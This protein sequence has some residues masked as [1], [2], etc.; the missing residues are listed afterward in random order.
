MKR[1]MVI[2]AAAAA[3]GT[4]GCGGS[5]EVDPDTQFELDVHVVNEDGASGSVAV[6]AMSN[7]IDTTCND[8]CTYAVDADHDA[9]LRPIDGGDTVF[10]G[11]SGDC[12]GTGNVTKTA[13]AG[14]T[15]DCTATFTTAG[16]AGPPREGILVANRR[17]CTPTAAP[18][19]DCAVGVGASLNVNAPSAT[20][21]PALLTA[22]SS[23]YYYTDVSDFSS[24]DHG[25]VTLVTSRMNA[26]ATWSN[27][28]YNFAG[29]VA[30]P[31]NDIDALAITTQGG[32]VTIDSAPA[33]T[34]VDDVGGLH[35][36]TDGTA[37]STRLLAF[38][39][40]PDNVAWGVLCRLPFDAD[41]PISSDDFVDA[42][43]LASGGAYPDMVIAGFSNQADITGWDDELRV[44]EAVN[45]LQLDGAT[46]EAM[47]EL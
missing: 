7:T 29:A 33:L 46:L 41:A 24:E 44:G 23:C 15:I 5:S 39:Y 18:G 31:F 16:N 9:E 13:A 32:T 35:L 17:T 4:V 26:T 38:G 34:L 14:G 2:S 8:D 43:D 12:E 30:Q 22:N 25:V 37:D 28:Y 36:H 10:V 19:F 40:T 21:D 27:G 20:L 11:W 47:G 3:F 6:V 45:W 42:I 1:L